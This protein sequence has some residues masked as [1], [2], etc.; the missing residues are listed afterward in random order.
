MTFDFAMVLNES[1]NES[2]NN[3]EHDLVKE[4]N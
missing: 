1:F 3:L 2:I 4:S